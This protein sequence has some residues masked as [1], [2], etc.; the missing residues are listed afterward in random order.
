MRVYFPTNRA[1]L[2][3]LLAGGT[4]P[5]GAGYAVTPSLRGWF[6]P[7]DDEEYEHA[8]S[9]RA[10]ERAAPLGVPIF[11]LPVDVPDSW[12]TD[13]GSPDDPGAVVVAGS[14]RLSWV[15]AILTGDDGDS[16]A[17]YGVQEADELLG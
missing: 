16:L 1:G 13:V 15:A 8:A 11:V 9:F 3:S 5:A 2:R 10:A 6:G 7:G 17:W 12:L 14:I 4:G